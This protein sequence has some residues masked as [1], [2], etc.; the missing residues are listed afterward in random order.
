ML[1]VGKRVKGQENCMCVGVPVCVHRHWSK[2]WP[3]YILMMMMMCMIIGSIYKRLTGSER[4][5]R[6]KRG[7]S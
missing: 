1:L 4:M 5:S 2:H 6:L 7:Q 3:Y